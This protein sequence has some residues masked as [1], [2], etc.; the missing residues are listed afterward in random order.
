MPV[1][2]SGG[3]SQ[4]ASQRDLAVFA[5]CSLIDKR[6]ASKSQLNIITFSV[7]CSLM[8][9]WGLKISLGAAC[10]LPCISIASALYALY[11]E[12]RTLRQIQRE[13][14]SLLRDTP[15]SDI[16]GFFSDAVHDLHQD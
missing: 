9:T 7:F 6:D 3:Y 8:G 10:I 12:S 14:L 5:L 11:T 4:S 16:E 2:V 1:I 15:R 13:L